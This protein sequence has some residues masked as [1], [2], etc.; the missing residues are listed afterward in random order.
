ME[1][2]KKTIVDKIWDLCVSIKFAIVLFVLIS[3]TSIVGTV[4][5]QKGEP[6]DN[7]QILSKLFGESLAPHLYAVSEKLGFTDMY[8]SWWFTAFLML[9]SLNLV[10]C[11]LDRLPK[12]W[13]LIKEPMK[14]MNVEQLRKLSIQREITIKGKPDTLKNEIKGFL[15]LMHLNCA[16]TVGDNGYQFYSQ[17]GRYSRL[18]VYITHLSILI[19]LVGA[20][21]GVRFGFKGY[22]NLP[23]GETSSMVFKSEEQEFPLGFDIRCETFQVD[24]YG[25]SDM[26][27][28]YRSWLTILKDGKEVLKKSITVNDPLTFNGI[29][30]YQSSYG[31]IPN[32]LERGVF[33]F[34]V[35]SAQSEK[36]VLNL[37]YG[38]TFQIPNTSIT[39]KIINFSPAFKMDEHGHT[40]TY[41]NQM[42][43]PAVL[44]DF[45][46]DGK[47]K[48]SGWILKRYPGTWILPEGQRVEFNDYWGVEFTGLQVRKDPGRWVVYIGFFLIAI[49]LFIAF[50]TSH[51]K[52]WV[53]LVEEKNNTR[54]IVGAT[55]NK[56]KSV[57]ERK[58]DKMISFLSKKQEGGK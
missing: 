32:G 23:E 6:S 12:I 34:N 45:S 40:S 55:A 17:K 56:N 11:S 26:P 4:L 24:F 10:L 14:P 41:A 51:R 57:F 29:T 39:G 19:I 46:E 30:F 1:H 28:E 7:I 43:N 58:I 22:L 49:G 38:D 36:T 44:I 50:F 48:F 27:Q 2:E 53:T 16:E 3:V 5:E 15:K 35:A 54:V 42:N 20:I 47:Y 31:M 18:G 52:I 33:L 9:F 8:H 21:I 37:R 25:N 13:R